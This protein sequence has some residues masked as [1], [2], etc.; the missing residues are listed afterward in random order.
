[1][2]DISDIIINEHVHEVVHL[3]PSLSY[4]KNKPLTLIPK[5]SSKKN[6]MASV[7]RY[8]CISWYNRTFECFFNTTSFF[9]LWISSSQN[10]MVRKVL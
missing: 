7:S 1:M 9:K 3:K 10:C 4:N 6:Y 8:T 5:G 2:L